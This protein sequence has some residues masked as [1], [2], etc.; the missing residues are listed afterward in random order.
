MEAVMAIVTGVS[1][2]VGLAINAWLQQRRNADVAARIEP[3][4]REQGPLPLRALA[5]ALDMP[6]FYARGKVVLALNQMIAEGRVESIP[7]PEGTPQLKKGE[8]IRY[9]L[10]AE[11]D[12]IKP[13]DGSKRP[14][15]RG[16][17]RR[18]AA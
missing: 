10:R 9:R 2:S 3:V 4:L 8:L 18:G 16:R 14:R 12:A 6:G 13:R 7:A 11:G 15:T 1:V 5:E 17:A